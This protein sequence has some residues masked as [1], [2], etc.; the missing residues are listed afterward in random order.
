MR[1]QHVLGS[2]PTYSAR[3]AQYVNVLGAPSSW[4][5]GHFVLTTAYSFCQSLPTSLSS[6]CWHWV[7]QGLQQIK[8]FDS[9]DPNKWTTFFSDLCVC[10]SYALQ[11]W[12]SIWRANKDRARFSESPSLDMGYIDQKGFRIGIQTIIRVVQDLPY[13]EI[14]AKFQNWRLGLTKTWWFHIK[15]MV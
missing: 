15:S 2:H 7:L 14:H 4:Y 5:Q 12:T 3:Q 8:P 9:G 10:A 13:T 11:F 1:K 6:A